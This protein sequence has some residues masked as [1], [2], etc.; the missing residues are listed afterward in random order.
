[1]QGVH[2]RKYGVEAKVDFELYE[3]D[4]VDFRTDWTPAAGDVFMMRD[5]A[6]EEQVTNAAGNADLS[7]LV[8]DE[9]RAYSITLALE[10]MQAARVVVYLVDQAT[11]AFL[12][13]CLIIETYGN[14]SAMHA[15]D[16]DT[17]SA[18]QT[19]DNE[20][21]LNTIE[22][23]TNEIQGKLPTNKFMGSSDGADDDGTL[24][25]IN[26]NAARLTAAR[27]GVLTDWINDGRLD[28]LL[29]LILEDTAAQDTTTKIRTLLTGADTPVCKDST[30]NTT[31]PDASGTAAGLH[32]TTDGKID[33]LNDFDAAATP[34]EIR[35]TGGT[36]GKNAAELVDDVCDEDISKGQHNVANS[37]AKK[38]RQM[39]NV[40]IQH[41]GTA[42]GDGGGNNTIELAAGANANDEWYHESWVVLIENTGAGQ[43]KHVDSYDGGTQIATMH[44]DWITKPDNTTDY[45]IIGRSAIHVDY[46]HSNAL[47]QI[48]TEVDT[49]LEDA[50]LDKLNSMIEEESAGNKF[51]TAALQEAPVA[52]GFNTTVP[53]AAGTA[54]GLHGTTDSL[55]GALNNLSPANAKAQADAALTDIHLDHLL[56][57]NYD[58]ASKPG[59]ATALLNELVENDGGVSR[60]TANALEQAPSGAGLSGTQNDALILI[61]DIIEGDASIDTSATPWQLVINK[62]STATE[63]LRKDLNDVDGVSVTAVATVIGQV[64]EP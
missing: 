26:T 27:A 6:A 7:T 14:A 36:A 49:A 18:A 20:T 47:A 51:T 39:E 25:T 48:N 5:E 11:K 58:P 46:L 17:A 16:L 64:M 31:V 33:A 56:A 19:A 52:E 4:G 63:K 30:P 29:D 41:E 37:L 24:D 38:I 44:G 50:G 53:D 61:R 28:A 23:D 9:G 55:I 54:A 59:V 60:L 13:K 34:V 43:I 8:T 2:L 32:G 45:I 40:F 3:I 1:M 35:A 62:K 42:R 10:D 15:F 57:V 21:R 22:T 12:D